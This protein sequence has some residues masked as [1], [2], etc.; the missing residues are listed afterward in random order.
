VL[1]AGLSRRMGQP[2]AL[3]PAA[4]DTFL[5]RAVDALRGG[6]CDDVTVAVRPARDAVTMLIATAARECGAGTVEVDSSEQIESLRAALRVVREGA[7]A[8]IVLPVDHPQVGPEVVTAL[9][10]GFRR[11]RAPVVVPVHRAKRGHP[12]LFANAVFD[13]LLADPLPEGARTVVHAHANE[14]L[15]VEVGQDSVL[16][17]VNTPADFR[18][19]VELES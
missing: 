16:H 5:R 11:S 1:A 17:D 12:V 18:R 3:L 14:L 8:V 10:D 13:E 6:G 2:K 19:V 9:I 7:A 15:E 4:G